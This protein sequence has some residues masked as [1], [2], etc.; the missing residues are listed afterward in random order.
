[1]YV[2]GIYLRRNWGGEFENVSILVVLD[3]N[4][5]GYREVI[6]A[7]EGI[8]G[9]KASWLA[10]LQWFKGRR[11]DDVRLIIGDMCFC[12]GCPR[13]GV[14]TGEVPTLYCPLLPQCILGYTAQ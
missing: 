12:A 1:M 6:G 8:K 3:V 10:F 11:L 4:E 2:D 9:Y 7:T 5:D 14:F 13:L